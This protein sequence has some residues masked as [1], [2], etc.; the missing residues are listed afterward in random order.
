MG[1]IR[2]SKR[3]KY[4]NTAYTDRPRRESYRPGAKYISNGGQEYEILRNGNL[5]KIQRYLG[6]QLAKK[7][8]GSFLRYTEAE[9]ILINY[10]KS[11]DTGYARYPGKESKY[12][13]FNGD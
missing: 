7:L 6:G 10:L 2:A 11:T 8:K 9:E 1:E 3:N 4:L 12:G 13:P 5:Y